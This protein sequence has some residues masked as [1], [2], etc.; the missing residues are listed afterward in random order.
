[1]VKRQKAQAIS[2]TESASLV[3]SPSLYLG[4]CSAASNKTFLEANGITHVL[5]IGST[6]SRKIEG[7]VYQ[8]LSL[9]DSATSLL[10]KVTSEACKFIDGAIGPNSK[11]GGKGKILV[12]CSAGISRSPSLV[13]AYLMKSR[14]MPLKAA[15][16]QVVRARP[17][18]SPNPGFLQQLKQLEEEL[19]GSVSLEV[20]ELPKR[21]QDRLALFADDAVMNAEVAMSGGNASGA[22]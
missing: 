18:V 15:L 6:P 3:L 19:F 13:V 21:E 16:G 7:V 2:L 4:P 22:G 5:S 12:H 10:S 20:D 14:H 1:M 17:Q 9:N 11:G 8:R